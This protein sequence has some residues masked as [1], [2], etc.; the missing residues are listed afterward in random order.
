MQENPDRDKTKVYKS[1]D[2]RS[3]EDDAQN[4]APGPLSLIERKMLEAFR[5]LNEDE[6]TGHSSK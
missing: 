6:L 4:R 5:E 2:L 1:D 3:G